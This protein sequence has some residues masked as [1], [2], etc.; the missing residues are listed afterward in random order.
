MKIGFTGTREG[1]TDRQK[2][3]FRRVLNLHIIGETENE[4]H[5]GDCIGADYDAAKIAFELGCQLVSHPPTNDSKRAFITSHVVLPAKPYIA[6]N[7]DIV[8]QTERM[9]ASPKENDEVIRSGTWATIRY[10]R[11]MGKSVWVINR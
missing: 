11:L 8:N 6:R 9:I 5:H 3:E 10:A 1:M 2:D 7:H 4:F